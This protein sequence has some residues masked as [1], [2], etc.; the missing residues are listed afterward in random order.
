MSWKEIPRLFLSEQI[1]VNSGWHPTLGFTSFQR[2]M[3]KESYAKLWTP[4][5]VEA[6]PLDP[7]G[8]AGAYT[9]ILVDGD[10]PRPRFLERHLDRLE[11]SCGL[12]EAEPPLPRAFVKSKV[13]EAADALES[14]TMLRVALIPAGLSL[15]SYPQ[16]GKNADLTGIPETVQRHLPAAKSL[17]DTP[18]KNHLQNY[19]RNLHELLLIDPDGYILEGATTNLLFVKDHQID[20]PESGCLAGITR[21]ILRESINESEWVW[22]P[23]QIHMEQ[24]P[25]Y[26]EILVCG[27]GKEVARLIRIEGHNWQPKQD[28]AF[29]ELS[30][31]FREAKES[32]HS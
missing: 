31:K 14:G 25:E 18:L 4:E 9:T 8:E 20:S 3:A 22:N 10:P 15:T 7:W 24:L 29:R 30:Q 17:M 21:Q 6:P 1:H 2:F 28:L 12:L 23:S 5:G 16:S 27:S 11:E 19:D 26:D 32:D 13:L